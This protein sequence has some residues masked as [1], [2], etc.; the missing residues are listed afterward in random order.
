MKYLLYLLIGY[1]FFLEK[2]NCHYV[3]YFALA[4]TYILLCYEM[5]RIDFFARTVAA[6]GSVL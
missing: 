3:F 6:I 2:V 4:F 1:I 5:K